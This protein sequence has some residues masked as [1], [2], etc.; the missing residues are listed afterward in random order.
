MKKQI[1]KLSLSDEKSQIGYYVSL[2]GAFNFILE[3][4]QNSQQLKPMR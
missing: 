3:E 1:F 4:F 2:F